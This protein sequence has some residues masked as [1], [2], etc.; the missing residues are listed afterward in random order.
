MV[1][2]PLQFPKQPGYPGFFHCSNSRVKS[3][4]LN[5]PG[6]WFQPIWRILVKMGSSSPNRGEKKTYLK[7]TPS[8]LPNSG[9][10]FT[11]ANCFPMVTTAPSTSVTCSAPCRKFCSKE[12]TCPK[13][14]TRNGW[15]LGNFLRKGVV[16]IDLFFLKK[17]LFGIKKNNVCIYIHISI[18]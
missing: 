2:H 4:Q 18:I 12:P 10:C 14:M 11:L 17:K 16:N 7:P 8:S 5:F 3:S 15:I 9:A 6:W 13:V 1:F